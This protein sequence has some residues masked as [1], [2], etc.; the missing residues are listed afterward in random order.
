MT[1]LVLEQSNTTPQVNFNPE[2]GVLSLSGYSRPEN[3]RDFYTP[4]ISWLEDF[5]KEITEKISL[6][7]PINPMEF[8]F[9]LI[10]FNSS[11]AKFLYD[12]VILLNEIQKYNV[13]LSINWYYDKEDSELRE[14]G[15]E[16]S[17]LSQ[18]KFNFISQ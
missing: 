6:G 15:E 17:E 2:E 1:S 7:K 8:Q 18:V 5:K 4:I 9:K 10:Y 12:I 16:L 3:V 11:S 13:P 14:A